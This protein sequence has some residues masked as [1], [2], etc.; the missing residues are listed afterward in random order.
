MKINDGCFLGTGGPGGPRLALTRTRFFAF[1]AWGL[2]FQGPM[3]EKQ[4]G[5]NF[6]A[7]ICWV[8]HGYG[9]IMNLRSNGAFLIF[10]VFEGPFLSNTKKI[11]KTV[12][13]PAPAAAVKAA[14][15]EN[16]IKHWNIK[17]EPSLLFHHL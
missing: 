2:D 3:L 6:L 4:K 17:A 9:M 15:A 13:A 7:E 8:W 14:C 10:F 5:G 1:Q 12:C 11:K 16:Y